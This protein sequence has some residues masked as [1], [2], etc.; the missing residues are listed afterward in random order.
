[1]NFRFNNRD[2]QKL[3]HAVRSNVQGEKFSWL[4]ERIGIDRKDPLTPVEFDG[5]MVE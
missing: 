2:K 5:L 1:M 4:I 3:G